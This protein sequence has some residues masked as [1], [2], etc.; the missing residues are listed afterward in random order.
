MKTQ[1]LYTN[2]YTPKTKNTIM[3]SQLREEKSKVDYQVQA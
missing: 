3:N 2:Y 1:T